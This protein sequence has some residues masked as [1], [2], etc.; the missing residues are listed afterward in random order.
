[1]QSNGC[2]TAVKL[3]LTKEAAKAI[4]A[5][6]G[7]IKSDLL[8]KVMT[9]MEKKNTIIYPFARAVTEVVVRHFSEY[10]ALKIK[11]SNPTRSANLIN[12][13]ISW[14]VKLDVDYL[15]HLDVLQGSRTTRGVHSEV[16]Q[17]HNTH[18]FLVQGKTASSSNTSVNIRTTRVLT[19]LSL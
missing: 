4:D 14:T 11:M 13:L 10:D 2:N 12:S 15:D 3:K 1:M 9:Y 5:G 16:S 7:Y 18:E 17:C 8:N 6:T 19:T